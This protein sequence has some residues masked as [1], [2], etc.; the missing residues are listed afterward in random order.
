M[1]VGRIRDSRAPG[2]PRD[3][4]NGTGVPR[5]R[6]ILSDA[7]AVRPED[8]VELARA[9]SASRLRSRRSRC[10][11][12]CSSRAP[13]APSLRPACCPS[14]GCSRCAARRDRACLTVGAAPTRRRTPTGRA[15]VSTGSSSRAVRVR[16]DE[17]A[18]AEL[19]AAR[20]EL[21]FR[22]RH[23]HVR[24]LEAELRQQVVAGVLDDD[25]RAG[26]GDA[27]RRAHRRR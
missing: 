5:R 23:L 18:G 4:L 2:T 25:R 8:H 15:R 3:F 9:D 19:A 20:L 24:E 22:R 21:R 12:S 16:D 1:S 14:C 17:R 10:T 6:R 26:A 11:E 13:R 7:A 27:A